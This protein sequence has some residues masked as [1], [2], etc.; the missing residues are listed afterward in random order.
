MTKRHRTP[1][2]TGAAAARLS[3]PPPF[4]IV[5]TTECRL[6]QHVW[7]AEQRAEMLR[8]AFDAK[9][10]HSVVDMAR[11][12]VDVGRLL[13]EEAS[14]RVVLDGLEQGRYLPVGPPSAPKGTPSGDPSGRGGSSV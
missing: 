12:I 10:W 8:D 6:A 14:T 13:L 7:S 3:P 1:H 4:D 9:A 2:Y 5:E 11:S